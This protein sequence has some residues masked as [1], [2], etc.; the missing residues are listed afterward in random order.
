MK[1]NAYSLV[2]NSLL[3]AVLAG[4]FM[5]PLGTV[6]VLTQS[7]QT[8]AQV[9]GAEHT[10]GDFV[11]L[12][13]FFDFGTHAT[14]NPSQS[15][16]TFSDSLTVTA[17]KSQVATYHTMYTI[18]NRTATPLSVEVL[19]T[20]IP[21][22]TE[23]YSMFILSIA[24]EGVSH[25]TTLSE[26]AEIGS[27]HVTVDDPSVASG[28]RYIVVDNEPIMVRAIE[29]NKLLIDPTTKAFQQGSAVHRA[30]L[31]VRDGAMVWANT[32]DVILPGNSSGTI[33]VAVIGQTDIETSSITAPIF[34]QARRDTR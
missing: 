24:A 21:E 9:A 11:V 22:P 4:M 32:T 1:H 19:L 15:G 33:N 31:L 3:I 18:L 29:G 16:N 17:F 8:D 25:T 26:Q 7:A 10:A 27:V 20:D 14:F 6:H 2:V 34:I 12:P 30:G 5:L 23:P 13:N 28:V